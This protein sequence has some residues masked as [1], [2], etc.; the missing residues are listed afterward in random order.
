MRASLY[1]L[2]NAPQGKKLIPFRNSAHWASIALASLLTVAG[3]AEVTRTNFPT[4]AEAQSAELPDNVRVIP[5]TPENINQTNAASPQS[6]AASQLPS[7]RSSWQYNIGVGDILSIIVWD[8]PELTLP[9]GPQRT[10]L[11]S[12]STVSENG[13]IFYPYLGQVRVAGRVVGDVQRELTERL[14][15][16]IPDPQIE[17]KV[18]AYNARKVVVTGAVN[19]PQSLPI[20][21]IPLTLLEA[22]NAS[23]G[24]SDD[25]DGQM[26]SIRRG[27]STSNVD[28]QNFLENGRSGSN[29]ILHG[30][31]IINVPTLDPAQAFILGKIKTPGIVEL[32]TND[33]SLTEAIALKGGLDEARA[34]A[35]GIFVF[36]N[37]SEGIDVYQLDAA[38]P[39]AFVLAT[40]FSLRSDDVVYIVSDPAARW[41][42]IIGQLIPTIGAVRQAQIIRNDG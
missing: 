5:L 20:T 17:V 18:A 9:A 24:L 34:D 23:G 21:N 32:G 8:H 7:A 2:K 22:V 12:G 1:L 28:L 29:P 11:E 13:A 31:D 25:A 38:T 36:R 6:H 14:Q 37:R 27:E 19:A 16:Y 3:C 4:S 40:K 26:V 39:L 33:V 42:E 15:E 41:N 35:S 10:Q 30:G